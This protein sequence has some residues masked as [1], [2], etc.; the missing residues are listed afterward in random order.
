MIFIFYV[1]VNHHEMCKDLV[2][3][4]YD[5]VHQPDFGFHGLHYETAERYRNAEQNKQ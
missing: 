4:Y 2:K 3:Q 1:G 5:F